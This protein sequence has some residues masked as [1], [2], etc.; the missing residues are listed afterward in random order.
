M[1]LHVLLGV[2]F[3]S[4]FPTFAHS[5][6]QSTAASCVR[7]KTL[8]VLGDSLSAGY[9]I[10]AQRGWVAIMEKAIAAQCWRV[11][12]ASVSGETSAGGA[13]RLAGLL[14]RHAPKLLIAQLGG[15]DG[16]RGLDP[17]QLRGN[18]DRIV[19]SAQASGAQVLLI[20]IKIPPNFGAA[21]LTQFEAS[22]KGVADA[23]KATF[24]PFLLASIA[25]DPAAFQADQLHPTAHAQPKIWAHVES[26]LR[27]ML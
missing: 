17:S 5:A 15:N 11:V 27:P 24:L 26:T 6:P 23:R 22:F 16:L 3:L 12:N 19:Q 8:L 14:K 7:P 18:L 2:L 21:Y 25:A 10:D 9:G 13:A 20:G 1:R 4:L